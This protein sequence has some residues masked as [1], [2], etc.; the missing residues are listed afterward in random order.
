M[1]FSETKSKVTLAKLEA[2]TEE[3]SACR[4]WVLREEWSCPSVSEKVGY[5]QILEL[6]C[7]NQPPEIS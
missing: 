6:Y 1:Q 5:L 3:K 7:N 2:G 4:N